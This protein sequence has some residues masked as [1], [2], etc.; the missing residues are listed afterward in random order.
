MSRQNIVRCICE[1]CNDEEE[2]NQNFLRRYPKGWQKI[3]G[4]LLC[5][6]CFIDYRKMFRRFL[7]GKG[8]SKDTY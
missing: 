4:A 6:S 5:A 3:E 7:D 8:K 1:R 2:F